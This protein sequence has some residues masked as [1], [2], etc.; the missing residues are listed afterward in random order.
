MIPGHEF[1]GVVLESGS[2]THGF[3]VGDL[4]ASGAAYS[5]GDCDQCRRGRANLCRRYA[6]VGLHRD[7]ALAQYVA[8]PASACLQ[9]APYGLTADA[10]RARPTDVDRRARDA[11][12]STHRL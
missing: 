9:V 1:A 11:A 3:A 6:T 8:V 12:R 7:G 4:V 5:C 10:R 2:Q